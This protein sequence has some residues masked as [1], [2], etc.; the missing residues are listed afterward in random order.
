MF[1]IDLIAKGDVIFTVS[2]TQTKR[3]GRCSIDCLQPAANT[4]ITEKC[5]N[6]TIHC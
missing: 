6:C 1:H 2:Q 4:I 3:T 5:V